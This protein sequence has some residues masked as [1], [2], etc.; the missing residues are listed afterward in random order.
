MTEEKKTV[1]SQFLDDLYHTLAYVC[2]KSLE[3]DLKFQQDGF[4]SYQEVFEHFEIVTDRLIQ[5]RRLVDF[6]D[7]L[8]A[9]IVGFAIT[10]DI[11]DFDIA[12]AFDNEVL[13]ALNDK[14][15]NQIRINSEKYGDA[16]KS[17]SA[18]PL[19]VV[20]CDDCDLLGNNGICGYC[21]V[22]L[23]CYDGE[24][25]LIDGVL[26]N[27][28]KKNFDK[29][30]LYGFIDYI[31]SYCPTIDCLGDNKSEIINGFLQNRKDEG[32]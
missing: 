19:K 27:C 20:Q 4:Y 12:F 28:P 17:S 6:Y 11:D 24:N 25:D 23:E 10:K 9:E 1:G 26:P 32:E 18:N 13:I 30:V 14:I 21:K 2:K 29:T 22:T 8:S 5:I 16:L 15:E 31:L 7:D 3:D